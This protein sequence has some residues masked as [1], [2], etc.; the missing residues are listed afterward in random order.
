MRYSNHQTRVIRYVYY[1]CSEFHQ[2]C[3]PAGQRQRA[4]QAAREQVAAGG[5][6]QPDEIKANVVTQDEIWKQ[7]VNVE[8]KGARQW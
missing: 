5:K 3:V 1:T 6:K 4:E 2:T 7:S 8:K